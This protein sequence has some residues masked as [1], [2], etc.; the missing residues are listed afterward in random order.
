MA[1][2]YVLID[3]VEV[4]SGGT[5]AAFEFLSIPQIY[6]DLVI[7]MSARTN[8]AQYHEGIDMLFNNVSANR[9]HQRWYYAGG[10]GAAAQ[11]GNMNAG[12]ASGATAS[13][14]MFGVNLVE[15]FDYADSAQVKTS[16]VTGISANDVTNDWL[17]RSNAQRWLDTSPITSI[18]LTPDSGGI[19]QQYSVAHLYGIKNS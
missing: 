15:I 10:S 17:W 13:A 3:S 12:H 16:H 6:Q 7:W 5:S 1:A 19:F 4:P 8:L 18:K 14:N 2:S 9:N 11:I